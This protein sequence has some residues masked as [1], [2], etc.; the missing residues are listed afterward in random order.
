M[1]A[2]TTNSLSTSI[3][4][5]AG[6]RAAV[7]FLQKSPEDKQWEIAA[8]VTLLVLQI[9]TLGLAWLLLLYAQNLPPPCAL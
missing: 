4:S 1:A 9:L 8:K 2:R 3:A 5:P 6:A 7:T